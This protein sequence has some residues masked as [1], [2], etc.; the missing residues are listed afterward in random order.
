MA[1]FF[2]TSLF[3]FWSLPHVCHRTIRLSSPQVDDVVSICVFLSI[4]SLRLLLSLATG[5]AYV[6]C[7]PSQSGSYYVYCCPSQKTTLTFTVV[8]GP[9]AS[10][11]VLLLLRLAQ[12][13]Q[14]TCA[15]KSVCEVSHKSDVSNLVSQS[16]VTKMT[17]Q[18][19]LIEGCH[20]WTKAVSN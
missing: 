13:R 10:I 18:Q 5:E 2:E 7:C 6:Y 19:N 16:C 1:V 17:S 3:S 11:Y 8:Y 4:G 12:Q 14:L 20:T 15:S 9:A